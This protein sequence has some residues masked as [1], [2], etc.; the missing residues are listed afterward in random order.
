MVETRLGHL[1]HSAA[2]LGALGGQL[3][4]RPH[5]VVLEAVG[6]YARH[7]AAEQIFALVGGDLAHREERVVV[8]R[9]H[10]LDRM[11][12]RHIEAARDLVGVEFVQIR[13]KRQAVARD[14][15]PRDG[16]VGGEHSGHIRR[17]LAQVESARSGHPLVEMRHGLLRRGAE[18][19]DVR[20]Y[21]HARGIAEQHGFDVVPLARD[22]I[23]VVILPHLFQHVVLLRDERLVVDQDGDGASLDLP[24]ADANANALGIE[25]LAPCRQ[26]GVVGLEFGIG[27]FLHQ[28]GTDRYIVVTHSLG[29]RQCLGRDD[30]VNAADLVAYLPTDFEKPIGHL[31]SV[32][33]KIEYVV[34][35]FPS[36]YFCR[37]M[38]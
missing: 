29:D 13:I 36:S 21:D 4:V 1:D 6:R 8:E 31:I 7:L 3:L 20:L 2:R 18:I 33:H 27:L 22:R 34:I 15:T 26:K 25:P 17:V 30:G 19:L 23:D 37:K 32:I 24:T 28:I 5:E 14:A 10:L 16:G 35:N 12:G 38:L 9:G 11:L